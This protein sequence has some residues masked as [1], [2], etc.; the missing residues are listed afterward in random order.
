MRSR[1]IR[2]RITAVAAVVVAVVLVIAAVSLVLLQR[3]SLTASFDQNLIQRADDISL[4]T[5]GTDPPDRFASSGDEG[6]VQIVDD[7]GLVVASTPNLQG[8]P[9]LDL[10]VSPGEDSIRTVGDLDIDDDAYRVLSRQLEGSTLH[11][12]ATF[13]V[14]TE[15]TTALV[16]SLAVTI[17]IVVAILGAVVWWL[18]GR[19]LQPVE[20]IRS[21]V[22]EI[23]ATDLHRRVPRPE[24][25]DEID[26]LASTMNE[27]LGRLESSVDRQQRFVADASH[28]LRSPLTRLRTEIELGLASV[29]SQSDVQR[30]RSLLDEV[31]D[32]QEMV[33]DLLYLAR[34]DAERATPTLKPLD[35][36]DIVL[37]EAKRLT[38]DGQAEVSVTAVSAA[39]V[40]GDRGQLSRAVKNLLDNAG[41]HASTTVTLTLTELDDEAVLTVSDDGPGIPESAADQIFS[42]FGR[43]DEA[44]TT[45]VG[46]TG[47]GLAIAREIVERHGGNLRLVNPGH[48]GAAFEITLPTVS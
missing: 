15:S 36:D 43:P 31:I 13:E 32:M 45:G 38:A 20:D 26:R 5:E 29:E 21:E 1:S 11:V 7:R 33:E 24:T 39:H 2:L 18:V 28:E 22:A 14:V 42:R 3:N 40:W 19:T 30:L 4:L 35:L 48:P 6:F 27:M 12:G 46:G 25:D 8:E 37:R 9:A 34:A 10:G 41:R 44:R 17:P 47:L 23:G 16:T